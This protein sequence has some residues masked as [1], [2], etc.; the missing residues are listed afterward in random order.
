VGAFVVKADSGAN[1]WVPNL[2]PTYM[3]TLPRDP[4]TSKVNPNSALG[5]CQTVADYN[6]YVYMSDGIDYLVMAHC[7]PEGTISSSDP[8]YT[9][10]G[11]STYEWSLRT[12]GARAW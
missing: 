4:N 12:P 5:T 7:T 3:A 11:G 1:G 8:F 9:P 2:A 6:C 10:G